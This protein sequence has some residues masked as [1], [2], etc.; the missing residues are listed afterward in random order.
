MEYIAVVSGG[1]D[2]TVAAHVPTQT[3][4]T[5]TGFVSFDY[6][7]RHKKELQYA[8]SQAKKM[9][10]EHTV[11]D[12]SAMCSMF[13]NAS[14]LTGTTPVPKGHYAADTM[15]QTVVPNRN[16]VM[17]SIAAAHAVA[18]GAQ[19]LVVGVHSGDHYIYPDCRPGFI[20]AV[21]TAIRIGNEGF[22]SDTFQLLAPF[23]ES[24][25]ADIVTTGAA[26]GIEMAETW[27]CYEGLD[28]HCGQCGTCVER[29]EAFWIAKVKDPT[30]Y[31]QPV[32]P[33]EVE[34]LRPW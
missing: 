30:T 12:M 7:Q 26:L 14:A 25:K 10:V 27:S 18:K 16:M 3:G 29:Q 2:S 8:S 32:T 17:M 33:V 11:V 15:R 23:L 20:A 31:T 1:L 13:G 22:I 21:E 28:R 6:G 4:G 24:T 5:C 19:G 9:G 34:A